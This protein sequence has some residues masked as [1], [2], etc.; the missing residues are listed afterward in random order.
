[1]VVDALRIPLVLPGYRGGDL[2]VA[3]HGQRLWRQSAWD[4]LQGNPVHLSPSFLE[5]REGKA[6]CLCSVLF[7]IRFSSV[8]L[9][10][11]ELTV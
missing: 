6:G 5:G 10:G 4:T 9:P 1:M 2:T 8:V 7:V 3:T 11:L